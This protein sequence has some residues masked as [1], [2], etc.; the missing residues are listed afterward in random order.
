[1]GT[2]RRED[3][4]R[5][6]KEP[7]RE[8]SVDSFL[9]L[10]H[11]PPA[12]SLPLSSYLAVLPLTSKRRPRSFSRVFCG[13]APFSFSIHFLL[14]DKHLLRNDHS[15]SFFPPPTTTVFPSRATFPP[16]S[17]SSS[18]LS[19]LPLPPSLHY[20]QNGSRGNTFIW[21]WREENYSCALSV[22][23]FRRRRVNESAYAP[24]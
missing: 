3:Q 21:K 6:E 15:S 4:G 17:F 16:S 9:C 12:C 19:V 22:D 13:L 14:S 7:A 23:F 2:E 5:G 8:R 10:P 1:M 24:P 18:P 11:C 20:Y